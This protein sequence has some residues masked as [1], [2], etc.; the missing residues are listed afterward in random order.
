[1]RCSQ[2]IICNIFFVV[3]N[4]HILVF[5]KSL[6]FLP[7][8][9]LCFAPYGIKNVGYNISI[10]RNIL[11]YSLEVISLKKMV[12]DRLDQITLYFKGLNY[13]VLGVHH[14]HQIHKLIDPN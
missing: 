12:F 3:L 11:L 14:Y 2:P 8:L 4:N 13:L 9:T 6:V 10:T 1:M 5:V 7:F